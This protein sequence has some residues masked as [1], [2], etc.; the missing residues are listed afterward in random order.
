MASEDLR[1]WVGKAGGTFNEFHIITSEACTEAELTRN[2]SLEKPLETKQLFE[3]L[4]QTL[5]HLCQ[6]K[7]DANS[8]ASVALSNHSHSKK[9]T[10]P[11]LLIP[12]S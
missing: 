3:K 12:S 2:G 10:K 9:R 5:L 4:A 11:N 1:L 6:F 7:C 8:L